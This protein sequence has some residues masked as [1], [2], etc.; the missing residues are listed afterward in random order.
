MMNSTF[1]E[2]I[3]HEPL[4][5][6]PF[7]HYPKT[8]NPQTFSRKLAAILSA[9]AKDYSRLMGENEAATVA[10][11]T[12]YRRAMDGLIREYHGRVVDSPGDNLLA[13]FPSAVEAV[14]CAWRI[15][16][17]IRQ[18]NQALSEG[19]RMM[20]RIGVNLG[21]IIEE[22]GRIYGDG[23]NIAARLE[24]LAEAGDIC[25]SGTVYDQVKQKVP[26]RF[27]Y[28]GEQQVKNIQGT[29]R[30]Y[31]VALPNENGIRAEAVELK[32]RTL[33]RRALWVL[34]LLVVLAASAAGLLK[35]IASRP[36]SGEAPSSEQTM[37]LSAKPSIAVLPFAN[38]S[39]DPQQEYFSDG[40]TNDIITDLSKFRSLMVLAAN[41]VFTYK[42]KAVRAEE[43]GKELGVRYVVE[44]SVQ[45]LGD[46]VR[47]NVQL[48]DA[49]EG[50]HLWAERYDRSLEDLFA[51]QDEIIQKVVAT[52][53]LKIDAAER[54]RAAHKDTRNMVAYDYVLRGYDAL[55]RN[56]RIANREAQEMFEK[57]IELDPQYAGAYV[58]LGW[59]YFN[60]A[61]DG[62][63]E[64]IDEAFERCLA[65]A[66][67]SL[68]IDDE[69]A[70][71]HQL[72][73]C[74]NV[75]RKQYDVAVAELD[76]AIALNP[77]D[78]NSYHWLGFIQ[79]WS[80]RVDQAI[81]TLQTAL[82]LDFSARLP[83]LQHLGT[84][85]YLKGR[86]A[87]GI[88]VLKQGILRDPDYAG[89]HIVLAAVYA[90]A[91]RAADAAR[92]AKIVRRLDPFFKAA[93]YGSGFSNPQDRGKLVEG[94]IK[95][96]LK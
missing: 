7:Y 46:R 11:L 19:R 73:G 45:K 92:E 51:V 57:A 78:A 43:I 42:G 49:G 64:F 62:W 2:F 40:I 91:G 59:V 23:V 20:F 6:Y 65:L 84:A 36:Q 95:A 88:R 35:F 54:A 1:Y 25:I 58:G 56:T 53:A 33:W 76:R 96:G 90:Q 67:K 13:E 79:L 87:D 63:T 31:R 68:E 70:S 14:N 66:R 18:R 21:D 38:L 47:I 16:Q 81:E 74:V 5:L 48:I 12:E 28:L 44:G 50:H 89:Y 39:E 9:D 8:M 85:Y 15:Q 37:P 26:L 29:V 60:R 17:E 94:L 86:Y 30:T 32:K 52:L 3:N 80:G 27:V 4:N 61:T 77:N 69:N 22:G 34:G 75:F 10:T 93:A 82:N 41:T 71:A 55:W 24:G 83:T 72:L